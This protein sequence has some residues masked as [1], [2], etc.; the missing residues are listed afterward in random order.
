MF[1]FLHFRQHDPASQEFA[2]DVVLALKRAGL[3]QK[4]AAFKMG[5]RETQLAAQLAGREHLSAWRLA[6]ID[7]SFQRHLFTIRL[8]RIG[9]DVLEPGELRE[10]VAFVRQKFGRQ[11]TEQA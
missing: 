10:L 1:F 5:I 2:G 11:S 8:T 6:R 7:G 9:C 3:S 4:E